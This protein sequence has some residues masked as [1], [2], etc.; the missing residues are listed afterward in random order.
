MHVT[1]RIDPFNA[2]KI[3]MKITF[4]EH[5]VPPLIIE[6]TIAFQLLHFNYFTTTLIIFPTMKRH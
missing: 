2:S 1:D 5:F 3:N 6:S 4:G